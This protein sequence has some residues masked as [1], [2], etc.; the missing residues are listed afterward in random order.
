M[1]SANCRWI[2]RANCCASCRKANLSRSAVPKT[3]KVN[4]RVVAATNRNLLQQV[5]EGKFRE[6]LY[7]RLNVFPLEVPPLRERGDDIALLAA[8]YAE[9][10]ARRMGRRMDPLS[11]EAIRRLKAYAWP[12]NI[13][14]LISV[15]E[16]AAIT[17][18]NGRLNLDRALPETAG[19]ATAS[20]A[21]PPVSMENAA[22]AHSHDSGSGIVGTSKFD[23]GAGD[24]QLASGGRQRRGPASGHESLDAQL[25][26]EGAWHQARPAELDFGHAGLPRHRTIPSCVPTGLPSFEI[27]RPAVVSFRYL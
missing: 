20:A 23:P 21:I 25:T 1:R 24:I 13:R 6:D 22:P 19:V 27:S 16:R 18:E 12:G 9:R 5:K 14:E 26:H 15:I 2:C 17:A 7:Y 4:V 10:F 11:P 8:A 3:R